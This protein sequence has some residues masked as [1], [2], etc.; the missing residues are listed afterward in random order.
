MRILAKT[1]LN[2]KCDIVST[3]LL[4]WVICTLYI[5]YEFTMVVSMVWNIIS[6]SPFVILFLQSIMSTKLIL[7]INFVHVLLVMHW[8]WASMDLQWTNRMP[9]NGKC[10][11]YKEKM[12]TSLLS[13]QETVASLLKTC[14]WYQSRFLDVFFGSIVRALSNHFQSI[15]QIHVAC[16]LT[17]K[18]F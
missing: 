3:N 14:M 4:D 15:L 2:F 8:H 17:F 7:N 5:M 10:G 16:T 11:T 13:N 9:L 6:M 18:S 12:E 1:I